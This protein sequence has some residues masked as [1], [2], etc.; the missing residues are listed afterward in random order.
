MIELPTCQINLIL[1]WLWIAMGFV[2]GSIIGFNFKFFKE[3]WQG[4]YSSLKRRL[5]RLGHISFFGLALINLMFYFTAQILI[6]SSRTVEIASC[7]FI[8]GT[9][10]MPICCI[11]M[12]NYPKLKILFYIPVI[13][14]IT[15]GS[16]TFWEVIKL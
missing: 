15:G 5:Y 8:V 10:T 9:I 2:S 16:L 13:S 6:T 1:A 7:A 14:L 3:D 11:I 12:A 4:G